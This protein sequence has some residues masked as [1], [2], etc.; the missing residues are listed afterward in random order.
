MRSFCLNNGALQVAKWTCVSC[1]DGIICDECRKEVG[2]YT[3]NNVVSP[4]QKEYIED[5]GEE[6][7]RS[8]T[9]EDPNDSEPDPGQTDISSNSDEDEVALSDNE[10]MTTGDIVWAKF[11]RI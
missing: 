11:G 3:T 8:E 5:A 6:S 7:D 9:R 1:S 4:S 10:C 2:T